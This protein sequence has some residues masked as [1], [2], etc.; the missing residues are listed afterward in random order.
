MPTTTPPEQLAAVALLSA[1]P[2]LIKEGVAWPWLFSALHALRDQ[3]P[4]PAWF[5]V[6]L[7]ALH[8]ADASECPALHLDRMGVLPNLVTGT[9]GPRAAVYSIA[10]DVSGSIID[11]A[12]L[13]PAG[14]RLRAAPPVLLQ[15]GL[16]QHSGRV[17]RGR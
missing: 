17:Q 10:S 2:N 8:L 9:D 7:E 11:G 1:A 14:R 3:V 16:H 12:G 15:A 13:R 4:D 6:A 5:D